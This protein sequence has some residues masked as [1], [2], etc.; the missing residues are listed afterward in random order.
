[1]RFFPYLS[2]YSVNKRLP[3]FLSALHAINANLPSTPQI[4]VGQHMAGSNIFIF[5]I[6]DSAFES[7]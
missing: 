4:P 5:F 3:K 2:P 7:V 6:E 1:M